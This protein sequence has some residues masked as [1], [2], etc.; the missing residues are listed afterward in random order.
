MFSEGVAWKVYRTRGG[1]MDIRYVQ[2]SNKHCSKKHTARGIN[3][4]NCVGKQLQGTVHTSN[5]Q[6]PTHESHE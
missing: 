2:V 4:Y 3:N 1:R 5:T 6:V